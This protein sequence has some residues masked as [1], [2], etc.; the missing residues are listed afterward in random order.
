M[1]NGTVAELQASTSPPL[2]VALS[3]IFG[4]IG[5]FVQHV[6]PIAKVAEPDT[7]HED[8]DY[9]APDPST[10]AG[11]FSAHGCIKKQTIELF[12]GNV[13][14]LTLHIDENR[15]QFVF[16]LG[17]FVGILLTVVNKDLRKR[18]RN[19][20]FQAP[21]RDGVGNGVGEGRYTLA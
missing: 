15:D 8:C 3:L 14:R 18:R 2:T 11:N 12:L 20:F 7:Y 1:K 5:S 9:A 17:I 6:L 21:R 10:V 19:P 13:W 4:S 16:M